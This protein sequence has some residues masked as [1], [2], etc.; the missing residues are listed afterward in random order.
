MPEP[1]VHHKSG[2]E[3]SHDLQPP[4]ELPKE[5]MRWSSTPGPQKEGGSCC[6]LYYFLVGLLLRL[7]FRTLRLQDVL[8]SIYD[9]ILVSLSHLV[10][11]QTFQYKLVQ[12]RR[13]Q[14]SKQLSTS[15]VNLTNHPA[16]TSCPSSRQLDSL[17]HDKSS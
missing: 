2:Q 15:I 5:P 14:V 10:G 11:V 17:R 12:I 6:P 8:C 9:S 1:L 7:A 13:I 16:A 3:G 4:E